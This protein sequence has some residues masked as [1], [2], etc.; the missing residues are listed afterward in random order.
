MMF[1]FQPAWIAIILIYSF[2]QSSPSAAQS[3]AEPIELPAPSSVDA[4]TQIERNEAGLPQYW[5]ESQDSSGQLRIFPAVLE[6][7]RYGP[8]EEPEHQF[9]ALRNGQEPG[10]PISPPAWGWGGPGYGYGYYGYGGYGIPSYAYTL[11]GYNRYFYRPW[12]SYPNQYAWS[13]HFP[14]YSPGGVG[15]NIYQPWYFT[16]NTLPWYSPYGVGPNI[17]TPTYQWQSYYP[18]YAPNGPGPNIYTPPWQYGGC[19]YW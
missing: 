5:I 18:W 17:Y 19:L 12:Y 6:T 1:R 4:P 8:I 7:R 15:P 13:N 16:R 9:Y 2:A 3:A 14:W 11:A 10:F